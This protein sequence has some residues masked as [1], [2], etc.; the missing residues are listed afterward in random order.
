MAARCSFSVL[1]GARRCPAGDSSSGASPR[2]IAL[3]RLGGRAASALAA[4]ATAAAPPRAPKREIASAMETRRAGGS[5]P[6][7]AALYAA[8][9]SASSG[10]SPDSCAG[11][12]EEGKG[13]AEVRGSNRG[14][15]AC[16]VRLVA[17]FC[18]TWM[19]MGPGSWPTLSHSFLPGYAG[20]GRAS[21]S[22]TKCTA[23]SVKCGV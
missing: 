10:R 14:G 6:A 7:L 5:P 23:T 11:A 1:F 9:A 13:G 22:N 8:T 15:H 21:K 4:C 17:P 18:A 19:M 2:C 16:V 3:G 20:R 12:K